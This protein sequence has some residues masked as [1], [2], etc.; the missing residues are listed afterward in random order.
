MKSFRLYILGFLLLALGACDDFLT[1]V[2]ETAVPEEEAMTDLESA[3]QIVVGIYSCFKNSSL[4]SG[5]LVQAT[6]IQTD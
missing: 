6:D 2:P 5:A 1:E 4:Y 3:E